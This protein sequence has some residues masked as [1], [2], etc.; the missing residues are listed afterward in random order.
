MSVISTVEFMK[1][2]ISQGFEFVMVD[3]D[4][5]VINKDNIEELDSLMDRKGLTPLYVNKTEK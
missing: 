2:C 5:K 4:N 3:E 1:F